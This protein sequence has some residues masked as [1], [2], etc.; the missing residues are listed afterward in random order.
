MTTRTLQPVRVLISALGGYGHYYLQTL[1]EQVAPDRATLAGVV[2]P[3]ARQARAWPWVESRGVPVFD[4]MAG[5][6]AAGHEADLAVI[7]SP[8]QFHVPQSCT[9]L[10]H[11]SHV[12]CDK[13]LG[14]T[15]QDAARL[16]SARDLADRFVMIG[17]QWSYSTAIQALKRD[18][19]EGLFGQP[20]RFSTLCCWP[21]HLAYYQRNP[22]A[23]RL[24]DPGT[25]QWVL[26]GPANNA[27]AHFLHNLLY[28]GGPRVDRSAAPHTV[29]AECYRAYPIESCD[30]AVCRVMTD[31]GVEMLLYASHVTEAPIEPRFT[32]EFESA[33]ATF[34]ARGGGIVVRGA[35]GTEKRYGAPD[36]SPQFKKLFDAIDTVHAMGAAHTTAP[37]VCGPEA[38]MAQTLALDGMHES[39]G[40]PTSFPDS[41]V[42]AEAE[43]RY[44]PGLAETLSRCYERRALPA[45]SDLGWARGGALVTL[46]G[47]HSFPRAESASG[48]GRSG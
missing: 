11:G 36:D 6:Y 48:N 18:I 46:D 26:D 39:V 15:V 33:V 22:W 47:Y 44:V 13:P 5:F 30:T 10:E 29:Q 16:V 7:V 35:S 14:A 23:G 8:I 34:D 37:I 42:A 20:V 9:A 21:R 38:A 45:E 12:L 43:R 32:L 41:M 2:D 3:M 17:Y 24:R 31:T 25:G 27:M 1:L 19:L 4:D 28:L 40:D